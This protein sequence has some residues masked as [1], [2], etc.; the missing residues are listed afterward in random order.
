MSCWLL[1]AIC[2]PSSSKHYYQHQAPLLVSQLYPTA[3]ITPINTA[4]TQ[5][6][7]YPPAWI[8]TS[9]RLMTVHLGSSSPS[10]HYKIDDL[11][12][13]FEQGHL[14]GVCASIRKYASLHSTHRT[15]HTN[16]VDHRLTHL[17]TYH[18]QAP[19]KLALLYISGAEND[20][21]E[22][23]FMARCTYKLYCCY[24]QTHKLSPLQDSIHF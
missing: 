22:I 20:G 8:H 16:Y 11:A 6:S 7:T 21:L 19:K 24:G 13:W 9:S 18:T 17:P 15:R 2:F 4:G 23:L 1:P 3:H 5:S 10:H 14:H 12:H